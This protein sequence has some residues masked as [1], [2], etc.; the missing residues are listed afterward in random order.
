M[1]HDL[2]GGWGRTST[3][4]SPPGAPALLPTAAA[5]PAAAA[6]AAATPGVPATAPQ[7]PTAPREA[8]H[9][10][11]RAV[12]NFRC[13]FCHGY[14][15]DSKT[16]ASTYLSPRPRDFTAAPIG[17]AAIEAAVREG[18]PGTAMK[19]F[20]GI[21][22]DDEVRA[23]TAFV[24]REFV[25][26]KARNTAYHTAEN[27]W[28]RHERH[29]AAFPFARGDIA[30]DAPPETLTAPQQAGRGLF[31]TTCITCH[32]RAR[33]SEEGP[34]WAAR[35][36]SYPRMGF[37]PGQPNLPPGIDAI[38]GASVYARQERPPQVAA[39]LTPQEKRGEK[40]FQDNCAFC[41]GGSGTGRNWIGQF[42]EP[43]ARDLTQYSKA[44]M[45]R[46]LLRQRIREGLPDTSMPAWKDVLEPAEVEAV[47]AY[48]ERAMFRA[49]P[50]APQALRSPQVPPAP[51][52]PRA[53]QAAAM[54]DTGAGVE[55]AATNPSR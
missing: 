51:R 19:S 52:A 12:Y 9:E 26:D 29:A 1:G 4:A 39:A 15:G 46:V 42:L 13:Y 33:V 40:L 23:V 6:P 22:S 16:L 28:P 50:G 31:L 54:G 10:R 2:G 35:P 44:T 32:D 37:Q 20:R 17:A 14:S 48:V 55:R 53:P 30:L 43:K 5:A 45:P 38:S 25:R 24:E 8:Q 27:G 18:K 36:L 34:V 49:E 41:H 7:R 21:L 47:A 3:A 11:G